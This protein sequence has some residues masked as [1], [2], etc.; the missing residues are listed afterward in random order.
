MDV[1]ESHLKLDV[2]AVLH[3]RHIHDLHQDKGDLFW[4]DIEAHNILKIL[5]SSSM[6]E[7]TLT[8]TGTM[9]LVVGLTDVIGGTYCEYVR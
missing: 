2:N 5:S 4:V 8:G 1:N 3:L 6:L 7:S 9:M